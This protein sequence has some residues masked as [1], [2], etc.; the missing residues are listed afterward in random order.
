MVMLALSL[1]TGF[2]LLWRSVASDLQQ[3]QRTENFVAAVTHE[4]RTPL[5]SIKMHGEMLL[6]GWARDPKKQ[7]EYYRRIVR[8][9]ERLSTLVERV[10][11]KARLASGP[12][13][14]APGDLS[15]AVASLEEQ[16]LRWGDSEHPDL[17]FDLAEDLPAVMLNHDAV[18][19]IVINL[20]ENA[21]KYAPVEAARADTD[22]IRVVTRLE[23][24]RVLL[25]VL[26]RGPGV[27]AEEREQIFQAF[28]RV[29]NEATRTARGTGLGLHLVAL[30]AH[31]IGGHAEVLPRP[32]GGSIFRV[33]FRTA[34]A[35]A[36]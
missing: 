12:A 31:S 10:L 30:H 36:A 5:A 29:G 8:E 28:Y 27:P 32:G 9:T 22:P 1:S 4:L 15:S 2:V 19:S 16:L 21:R 3:A 13:A 7:Q 14:P 34:P 26:D 6:D 35:D 11:E 33:S 23:G 20:V 25:E 24:Q 18:R 17:A